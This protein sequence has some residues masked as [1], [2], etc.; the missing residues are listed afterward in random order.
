MKTKRLMR[1]LV[2]VAFSCGA[3]AFAERPERGARFPY[4]PEMPGA[5]VEVY[6]TVG[7][8]KLNIYIYEPE[9]H[10]AEDARPAVVFFFGGG[11]RSGS[12]VQFSR[13]CAY[14]ASRG[15]VAMAADYRVLSRHGVKV[16]E[17][18]KDAK[19]AVRWIRANAARLGVDPDRVAAGGG[20]AGGLLAACTGVVPG[21]EEGDHLEFSSVP[22]AMAL[23]NPGV[24]APLGDVP[25]SEEELE[26]LRQRA[27]VEPVKLSPA[28]HVKSGDPPAIIFHGLADTTVPHERAELFTKVMVKAG[29]SCTLCSYEGQPHGFFNYGRNEN[30]YFLKTMRR[31]DEFFQKLG[32][33]KGP[34]TIE[35][36][37]FE[38]DDA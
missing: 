3:V 23:F 32:W 17:C 21:F 14:L 4:P 16:V 24:R 27:G 11:F 9:G 33:I 6:R 31:L 38:A 25:V 36:F 15:M 35:D 29:V 2:I 12:P 13:Q 34:A 10:S 7:D 20:S 37:D 1:A 26:Y 30:V 19:S 28:D 18:V 22:N 8:V 5:R